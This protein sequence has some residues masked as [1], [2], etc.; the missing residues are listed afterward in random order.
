MPQ[1][2]VVNEEY[3]FDWSLWPQQT[4]AFTTKANEV[5]FGGAKGPGKSFLIRAAMCM[6]CIEAPGLQCYLF[7]RLY[8]DLKANHM[9]GPTSFHVML[10]KMVQRQHARITSHQ[11]SFWN[12]ARIFLNHLQLERHVTK[13]QGPEIH[14]LGLD[15][16]TQFSEQQYRYLRGSVRL[17]NWIP[18][19]HMKGVFP[20]ILCGA[21]PGGISHAFVKKTFIDHGAYNVVQTEPKE[22][23]MKRVFIPA[24]NTD[25]PA[26]LRNDPNYLDRLEGMGDAVLVRAMKEGDWSVVAGSMFGEVWRATMHGRPWH[27]HSGFA[28]PNGWTL[29]R[30]GDDGYA[31]ETA[32]YWLTQD[33]ERKTI[34]IIDELYRKGMLP[35]EI[36]RRVLERDKQIILQDG[37]RD[38]DGKLN[39]FYNE[40]P[41]KGLYDNNA[42]TDIGQ[43]DKEGQKQITRGDQMNR[44]GCKWTPAQKWPGSRVAG[45]QNF[46]RLL[47]PNKDAPIMTE[48]GK[49]NGKQI[50]DA[51]GKPLHD[52]PGLVFFECCKSA[53]ETIPQLLRDEKDP[54]DISDNAIDHAFDG[55]RYGIQFKMGKTR[56]ITV[57]GI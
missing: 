56:R 16:L 2:E 40:E 42:F 5:L 36:A 12:G 44:L 46:H 54:E 29:W 37:T 14:F 19:K 1:V 52:R 30:G 10:A 23:G 24:R 55:C 45:V 34:Y 39:T 18:P 31:A 28:I 6:C 7:R 53:I 11:I 25:N 21:N 22:G 49:P 51:N 38:A 57:G 26:L 20:R 3:D 50:L 15:E 35:E 17:G 41:L 33:P 13:Y 27:V 32:I 4:L 48:N 43:S 8:P 47:A 9:E